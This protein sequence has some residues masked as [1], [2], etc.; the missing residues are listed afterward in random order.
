MRLMINSIVDRCHVSD[1]LESIIKHV[2]SRLADKHRGYCEMSL[3]MKVEF[4]KM[5]YTRTMDN[6]Q[7]YNKV[8]SGRF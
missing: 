3:D 8:I 2:I 6:R 4:I 5:I 7:F 1:S